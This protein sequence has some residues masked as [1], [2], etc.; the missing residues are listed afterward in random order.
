MD[1]LLFEKISLYLGLLGLIVFM[2]FIIW[3]L[4]KKSDAGRFG[5]FVLFGSL[6]AGMMGFLIKEVLIHTL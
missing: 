4:A 6:G 2:F 1:I 3:D 5:T